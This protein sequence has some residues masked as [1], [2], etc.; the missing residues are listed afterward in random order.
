VISDKLVV[1]IVEMPDGGLKRVFR[2]GFGNK[3]LGE[4]TLEPGETPSVS[5]CGDGVFI[6]RETRAFRLRLDAP[7]KQFTF[8]EP[9]SAIYP[10]RDNIILVCELSV[11]LMDNEFREIN[12]Y[13]SRD[14]LFS[15]WWEGEVL[16]VPMWESEP[17]KF[18][19]DNGQLK[20]I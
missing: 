16:H 10:L 1:S 19:V 7:V 9:I 15:G 17:L 8:D 12:R 14:I 4:I 2:V 3:S 13:H 20:Q 18:T 5:F 11:R 6:W